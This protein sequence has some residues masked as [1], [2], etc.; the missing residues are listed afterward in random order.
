MWCTNMGNLFT[1]ENS[2]PSQNY[3][4]KTTALNQAI[5]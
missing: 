4:A 3:T 5:K 2:G 1:N